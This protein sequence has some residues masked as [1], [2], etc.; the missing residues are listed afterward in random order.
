MKPRSNLTDEE[1]AFAAKEGSESAF[2]ELVD[3]YTPLV[4][5][6][7]ARITG[8]EQ[9]A[10]EVVQETFLRAF[11]GL[12][13]YS[14]EKAGFKTWLLAI[15]RNQSINMFKSIRRHAARFLVRVPELEDEP[16]AINTFPGPVQE[17]GESLLTT[18]QEILRVQEAVRTLPER[19]RTAL[20]L[21]VQEEMS[22]AETA[23]IMN[24]SVSSVESLI[25][26]ARK[27]LLEILET[28]T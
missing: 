16:A 4:F 11:R 7:A 1:L 3:R 19:Q 13:S 8:S 28:Q 22:Y 27:K 14:P 24:T 21:T 5:R 23:L 6:V 26:R 18:K 15:A 17:N 12:A 10:E 2:N 9:E 20:M 25:F